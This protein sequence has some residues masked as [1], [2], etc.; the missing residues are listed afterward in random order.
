[1][2]HKGDKDK[3]PR[4]RKRKNAVIIERSLQKQKA[5]IPV[6]AEYESYLNFRLKFLKRI[7]NGKPYKFKEQ[8]GSHLVQMVKD[9]VIIRFGEIFQITDQGR[10]AIRNA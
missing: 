10:R 9:G 7:A 8:I 4:Q 5:D 2:K 6:V 1:M 3:A